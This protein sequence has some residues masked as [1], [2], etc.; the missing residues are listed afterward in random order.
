MSKNTEFSAPELAINELKKY[1][2]LII[3]KTKLSNNSFN[4]E[5]NRLKS[6]V[7]FTPKKNFF[8]FIREAEKIAP[9]KDDVDF[10]ALCLKL[11]SPLW[12]NDGEL[13]KQNRIIV[14]DTQDIINLYLD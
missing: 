3:S 10:L 8:D 6:F 14:L 2:S 12:S 9:D 11:N 7:K 4:L 1:S 13:K 5:F